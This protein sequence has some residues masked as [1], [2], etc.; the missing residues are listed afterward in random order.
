MVAGGGGG[1]G[2]MVVVVVRWFMFTPRKCIWTKTIR[3]G[4]GGNW[5]L[6]VSEYG[7]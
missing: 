6:M 4:N 1:G 3:V 7:D 2:H 5:V